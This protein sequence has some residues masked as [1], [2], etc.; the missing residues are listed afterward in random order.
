MAKT[1]LVIVTGAPGAGKT[2]VGQRIAEALRLPFVSKDDIK[3]TLFDSLGWKD[4][5]WSKRLGAAAIQLMY[6]FIEAQ[7]QAGRSL[8][9]ESN[10]IP[11]LAARELLGLQRKY[12]FE[13]LQIL[14]LTDPAI[15]AQRYQARA[16]SAERHA[17]HVDHLLAGEFDADALLNK[18]GALEIGGRV[19]RVDTSDFAAIDYESLF[20]AIRSVAEG[21]PIV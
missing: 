13:P 14:C 17:G 20:Q 10:F 3:E 6:Y 7:L 8:I 4:R 5:E 19:L 18:H 1:L 21:I 12:P 9:A 15:L 11:E 2:T 16:G